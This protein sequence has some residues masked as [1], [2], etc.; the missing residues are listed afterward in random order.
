MITDEQIVEALE[1]FAGIY[2]ELQRLCE[3]GL[4]DGDPKEVFKKYYRVY[5]IWKELKNGHTQEV[6]P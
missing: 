3:L 6:K 1:P 2:E 4:V 5:K